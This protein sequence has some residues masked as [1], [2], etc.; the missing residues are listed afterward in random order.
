MHLTRFNYRHKWDNLTVKKK[1]IF[2]KTLP[3]S[4]AFLCKTLPMTTTVVQQALHLLQVFSR[5]H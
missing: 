2:I 1:K 4:N 3:N 5:Q